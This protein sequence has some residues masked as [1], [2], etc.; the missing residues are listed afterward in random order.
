MPHFYFCSFLEDDLY[1][2]RLMFHTGP[3]LD[4]ITPD[5]ANQ[6]SQRLNQIIRSNI[7]DGL[8]V[9]WIEQSININAFQK[10]DKTQQNEIID[11]LYQLSACQNEVGV[12]SAQIYTYLSKNL[13]KFNK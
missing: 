13:K 6:V 7:I 5:L 1:L 10:Q 4:K 2:M 11:T 9:N 8:F 12:N 3:V